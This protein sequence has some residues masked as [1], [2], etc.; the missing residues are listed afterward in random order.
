MA[1][2]RTAIAMSVTLV[3]TVAQGV[4]WS[5]ILPP[6][7]G[8]VVAFVTGMMLGAAGYSWAVDGGKRA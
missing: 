2:R 7:V 8:V 6:L 5:L 3:L 1:V 4:A